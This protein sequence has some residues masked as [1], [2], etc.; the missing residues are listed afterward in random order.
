MLKKIILTGGG[1]AGHIIPN[2][3]LIPYLKTHFKEIHYVGSAEGLEAELVKK[4][5][6]IIFHTVP[7]V[8]LLRKF[9]LKNLGI[10][11]KLMS[12]ISQ[13]KKLLKEIKPDIIFSKGGFV[14]L[15]TVLAAKNI[16]I[17]L[18]ESDL[19]VGL[20]NKLALKKCKLI[21]TSFSTTSES[22]KNGLHTG[23]PIRQEIYYGN[24]QNVSKS[25]FKPHLPNLLIMGG[26][27]GATAINDCIYEVLPQL[28][29]Y[30]NVV[31][32]V[33]AKNLNNSKCENYLQ[34][35]FANNIQDYFDWSDLCISRGGANALFELV[36]LNKPT[37]CIPLPKGA[38]RGDQL[39]NADYFLKAECINVLP[40][41]RLT[42]GVLMTELERLQKNR[43]NLIEKMGKATCID[44]TR[45]IANLLIQNS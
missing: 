34:L 17:I 19:T 42:P 16:P 44:G 26:S 14:A 9:T 33:G 12:G 8:K 13:A 28:C 7:C 37:L 30:Y 23:S 25:G 3:A 5:P 29:A 39:L 43:E 4:H 15:P 20:A 21:C 2:L 45:K 36:A 18:H 22:L 35:A 32:I 10:P 31:H 6:E 11:F 40:Q 41:E 38:S 1:T 24:G 27:L